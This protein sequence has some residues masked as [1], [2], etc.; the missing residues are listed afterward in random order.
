MKKVISVCSILLLS[1]C[2]TNVTPLATG[3]SKADGTVVVSY[4]YGAFE[5]PVVDWEKAGGSAK[6]RCAAWGY[7]KAVPFEGSEEKCL[8]F[9]GYGDCMRTQV[10]TT[11]QCT[12]R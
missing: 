8:A 2:A 6:A 7:K 10:N 9:N 1:A 12:N 4:S 3:G 11:Y 5:Q